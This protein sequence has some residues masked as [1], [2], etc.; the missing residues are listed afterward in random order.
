MKPSP[1]MQSLLRNSERFLQSTSFFALFSSKLKITQVAFS[2]Y[3]SVRRLW[4]IKRVGVEWKTVS[5][6]TTFTRKYYTKIH[7]S[8]EKKKEHDIVLQKNRCKK[9][10]EAIWTSISSSQN[11]L[12]VSVLIMTGLKVGELIFNPVI[13]VI[14]E[15]ALYMELRMLFVC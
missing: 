3:S 15:G 12:C 9:P 6:Y 14:R 11:N 2:S 4:I 13:T 7:L 1:Y 8:P 10:Q 5:W